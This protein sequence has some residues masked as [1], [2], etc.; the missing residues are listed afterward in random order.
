MALFSKISR[1][2]GQLVSPHEE[3]PFAPMDPKTISE[4]LLRRPEGSLDDRPPVVSPYSHSIAPKVEAEQAP[5]SSKPSSTEPSPYTHGLEEIYTLENVDAGTIRKMG[6]SRPVSASPVTRA[7]KS[8]VPPEPPPDLC[9]ELGDAHRG[10]MPSLIQQEPIQ[11]LGLPHATQKAL[12]EAGK[13][14]IRDLLALDASDLSHA[15][16]IG[17]GHLDTMQQS[18]KEYL[19]NRDPR[20]S[21]LIEWES[22]LLALFGTAERLPVYLLL[23]PYGLEDLFSLS[24]VDQVALRRE[25][26]EGRKAILDKARAGLG[27]ES[28]RLRFE[29]LM[30]QVVEV[31]VKPWMRRRGGVA[32]EQEIIER[33]RRVSATSAEMADKT[34]EALAQI[35][36][37]GPIGRLIGNFVAHLDGTLYAADAHT[38]AAYQRVSRLILSYFYKP[39][40]SYDFGQLKSLIQR[41]LARFWEEPEERFIERV[42]LLSPLL[43]SD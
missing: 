24:P 11:V 7:A 23:T 4:R 22:L 28:R 34:L 29:R 6:E 19:K 18:L 27:S 13:E 32:T 3:E 2:L 12:L 43:S 25:S 21:A 9:L 39:G 30:R 15:S 8:V 42:L 5:A 17:Q 35:F 20:H 41:D 26:E 40:L 31:H 36:Y 38:A 33:M 14:K 37:Q 10:W 1:Q 16:G